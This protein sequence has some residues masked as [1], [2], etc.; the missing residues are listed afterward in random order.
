[1]SNIKP[2]RDPEG[3]ALKRV[4]LQV[5][6]SDAQGPISLAVRR[7]HERIDLADERQR[8]FLIVWV[9]EDQVLGELQLTDLIDEF[10]KLKRVNEERLETKAQ[11]DRDIENIRREQDT[12]E[13]KNKELTESLRV[14][15][16]ERDPERFGLA[17]ADAV[18]VRTATL[19][20]QINRQAAEK[21][22]LQREIE[23]LRASKRKLKEANERLKE[24]RK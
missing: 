9:S 15:Q 10:D 7:D 18:K 24:G 14:L 5:L 16:K 22:A 13:R 3:N 12:L 17:V 1:M 8:K 19:E 4:L 21:V 2:V 23:E 11:L 20:D 6:D